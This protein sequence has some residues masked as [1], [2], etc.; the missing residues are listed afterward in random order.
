MSHNTKTMRVN[1]KNVILS[2]EN[3]AMEY[4]ESK[5]GVVHREATNKRLPL[6]LMGGIRRMEQCS[7]F[8]PITPVPYDQSRTGGLTPRP[9]ES[10]GP[11]SENDQPSN[12]QSLDLPDSGIRRSQPRSP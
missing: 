10:S 8:H 3:H 1:R 5:G 7:D 4:R 11:G 2:G 12:Q 6:S 9:V